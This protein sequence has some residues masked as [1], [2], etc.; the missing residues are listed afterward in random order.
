MPL[1]HTHAQDLQ[2]IG[3]KCLSQKYLTQQW[4]FAT[5]GAMVGEKKR[6]KHSCSDKTMAILAGRS[7]EKRLDFVYPGGEKVGKKV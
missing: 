1:V 2:R 6:N 4:P 7:S 5:L 3:K